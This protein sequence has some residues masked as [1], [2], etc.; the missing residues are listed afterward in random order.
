MRKR[1]SPA[2]VVAVLAL[3]MATTGAAIAAVGSGGVIHAC[4]EPGGGAL[5]PVDDPTTC[6][7]QDRV[8]S[9]NQQ[10]VPGPAGPAG[11]QGPPGPA[12][13]GGTVEEVVFDPRGPQGALLKEGRPLTISRPLAPGAYSVIGK[14]VVLSFSFGERRTITGDRVRVMDGVRCRLRISGGDA[15]SQDETE[16]WLGGG[17]ATPLDDLVT[18]TTASLTSPGTATLSCEV[19][20]DAAHP[21]TVLSAM[22]MT[23]TKVAAAR[24]VQLSASAAFGSAVRLAQPPS[25]AK[26][27]SQSAKGLANPAPKPQRPKG[28]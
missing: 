15:S 24:T 2:M 9:W 11:P 23:I 13:E 14:A 28:R 17:T 6:S 16:N 20:E 12:A 25:F 27:R 8:L 1:P 10:G 4:Y 3:A 22:R 18:T 7:G 19:L 26:V 5:R 21:S